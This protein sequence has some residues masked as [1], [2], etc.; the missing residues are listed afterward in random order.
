MTCLRTHSGGVG[1]IWEMFSDYE[2]E[3]ALYVQSWHWWAILL[4]VFSGAWAFS[5]TASTALESHSRRERERAISLAVE[6]Q[7]EMEK[8]EVH[9][10][11]LDGERQR[12]SGGFRRG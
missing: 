3:A 7:E 1:Q 10:D 4:K 9:R 12:K 11:S 6:A 5:H 2:E 8:G